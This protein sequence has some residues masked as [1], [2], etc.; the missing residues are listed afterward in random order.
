[1]PSATTS[2]PGG[3]FRAVKCTSNTNCFAVGGTATDK[4]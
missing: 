3:E 1:M 2:K 4:T